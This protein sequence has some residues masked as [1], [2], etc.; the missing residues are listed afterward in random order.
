MASSEQREFLKELQAFAI[1]QRL[2][3]EAEC[4]KFATDKSA[5]DKRITRTEDD[6]KFFCATYFPHYIKGERSVFQEYV[7]SNLP[8]YIDQPAGHNEV[9]AAP[10]G[11]AKSTLITQLLVL[12]CAITERKRFPVIIMDAFDQAAMMLEAIKAELE[13]NP[14]LKMDYP[15]ITG[16]GRVWQAGVIVS[17]NNIKIQVAGAGKKI[18]GWR[19]GPHRPDLVVL[20]DIENDENVKSKAQRD[21]LQN[22][23]KQAVMK[24]GPPDGSMDIIYVGTVLHYDSV[25]NRTLKSPT[26]HGK[27]FRAII[28]WPDNM[29]MWDDWEGILISRGEYKADLFYK[30]NKK[31]MDKGAVVSWPIPGRLKC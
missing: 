31:A 26:W 3:I 5:S 27:H 14:R 16:A 28:R 18:R 4:S 11:E 6:F 20:D 1:Q 8:G 7:Y 19:H 13:F 21:K 23:L 22:W 12:W 30:Q 24:L 17:K 2:L 10:R 29:D 25:L 15:A 9:I